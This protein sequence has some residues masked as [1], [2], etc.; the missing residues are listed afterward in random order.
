MPHKRVGMTTTKKNQTA[1][2]W[3][4]FSVTTNAAG[5]VVG[6]EGLKQDPDPSP[7]I[8]GLPELVDSPLRIDRPYVR[9][10]YLRGRESAPHNR[11]GEAFVPVDWDTALGMVEAELRRVKAEFGNT[12]IYGGSYGWASAG[13]FHHSPSVLKRFLGLHGG[14]VDKTGNHSYGAALG[15]MPYIL[16]RSDIPHLVVPWEI[17]VKHTELIVMFGGAAAKN[18]QIDNG[19]A[20]RHGNAPWRQQAR[21]AGIEVVNISP[22]KKDLPDDLG[23]QWLALRPN[24]D[25]ALML[26]LAHTLVEEGL[27]DRAFLARYCSGYP[28]FEQYLLGKSDGLPKNAAWAAGISGVDAATIKALARRMAS[29]RTLITTSWSVQR[30]DHGEQPVWMTVTLAAMLGQIGL[31]GRGFSIGFGATNSASAARPHVLPRPTLPLGPN[32]VRQHFPVGRV[33]DLLL[34]PGEQ[35]EHNGKVLQIPDIKL[36]YSAGGN[37]FHHNTNLNRFLAGWQR[38]DTIIVHEPWW[39]PVARHADI[40]LPATTPMERNDILATELQGAYV[41]MYKTRAPYK[42]ARNDFDIFAELAS[43]LGFGDAYTEGR[44]EMGW[45]R[46][47]YDEACASARKDGFAPPEFEEFWER[48]LYEFP[49]PDAPAVLLGN[50]RQD[51][52]ACP[53]KTPSG[54]IEIFSETVA[55]YGYE[56][57][58]G[59]PAWREPYE[60]LGSDKVQ[61]YPFHLLSNQPATRLHSQLDPARLSQATKIGGREPIEIAAADARARGIANGDT[62]RVFNAR[63]AFLAGAVL[64]DH[65]YPGVLQ[66]A[67]GAWFDPAQG[68]KPGALEKGGNP[69]VVTL[70]K[71]TS[72]LTQCSAAQ[73]V[74]VDL[75]KVTD[76]PRVTSYDLPEIAVPD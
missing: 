54:K 9:A 13:R 61:R 65:L 51:P 68:G 50:F 64:V 10:G 26:G 39:N 11:G 17:V 70:D 29:K 36:V 71:G 27:Q 30:G 40:V 55:G 72:R 21:N 20:V 63:G 62:V 56:E 7:L 15:V 58:P 69:N 37:P 74:L 67:T 3:G 38:P 59:H 14:Y 18:T 41:A 33:A 2:H 48:G 34:R 12:A 49:M 8:H 25:V 16:G 35:L 43:R 31:P 1:S 24:T 60:W 76:A 44:D 5:D 57:C 22:S 6:V 19:G 47:M 42:S 28:R 75:E 23:P 73:T 52:D 66:I 46:H 32:P 45:L 53:L 4:V